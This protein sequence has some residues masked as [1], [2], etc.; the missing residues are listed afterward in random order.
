[1]KHSFLL[2]LSLILF[3][4]SVNAQ[5]RPMT[6]KDYDQ[7]KAINETQITHDGMWTI[8]TLNPQDGD[9]KLVFYPMRGN[10]IDTVNRANNVKISPNSELAVFKI[11][12]PEDSLTAAKKAKKKKESFPK[13]SLGIYQLRS[14][15]LEKIPAVKSFIFPELNN[16]WLAYHHYAGFPEKKDTAKVVK[17]AP[18]KKKESDETGSKLVLRHLTSKADQVFNFVYQYKFDKNAKRLAFATTGN[19]STIASGLYIYHTDKKSLSP[20]LKTKAKVLTVSFSEDGNQ[21]AFLTDP[22]TTKKALK[23][24]YQLYYWKADQETAELVADSLKNPAPAKWTV[25]QYYE[26]LFSKDGSKLFFGTVPPTLVKDTTI[27]EEDV[28]KV[29]VWNWKD[30]K[31]MTQQLATLSADLKKSYLAVFNTSNKKMNQLATLEIPVVKLTKDANEEVLLGISDLRYSGQHWDWNGTADL[32]AISVKDGRPSKVIEGIKPEARD[33][34]V[35]PAGKYIYWYSKADTAWFAYNVRSEKVIRLTNSSAFSDKEDDDHPDY[36][37]AYGAAGWTEEDN[38]LLIYDKFDIWS[39]DPSKGGEPKRWTKGR[40]DKLI[41]RYVRLDKDEKFIDSKKTLL[42]H[43]FNE[44]S[45]QSGYAQMTNLAERKVSILVLEDYW[46]SNS[47]FKAKEASDVVF[48]RERFESFPDL[49][50]SADMGFKEIRKISEANP[51]QKN[52]SWGSVEM[53]SWKSLEGIELKGLLYKPENFDPSKKYPMI[54]YFYEK[55]SDE[56]YRYQVPQPIRASVNYSYYVSNGYVLFVPDIVYKDGYPGQSAYNCIM[57]GVMKVLDM[58]FVD[59]TKLGIQGHS[60]GGY[61]TAYLI[62]RTDLFTAAEAGAPV[63]NMTSAYGG[64]RWDTGLSRMAQYENTQSRIGATLWEKQANY[65][66]NSPLFYLPQ[67]KTPLLMMHNDD[68]G[69]VPWYQGIE[70]FMGLK[71]LNKPVWMVNY[72]G[73][74]HGLTQRKNRKDWS[75]RMSQFFDHYL[76]GQ[77]APVWMSKGVPAVEKTLNYGFKVG[78]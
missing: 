27:L 52:I 60:W 71:R 62:T 13:D 54:T 43:I 33:L 24:N 48:T 59:K 73:E 25:S 15:S 1:M 66:E 61:Q 64:I 19:D 75:V 49:Y 44:R 41:H 72:N 29:D 46:Y 37:G 12:V 36:P 42:L 10:L 74:K 39:V 32:Y 56:L 23:K 18:K 68:D 65:I 78:D 50:T 20:V 57:P 38:E 55:L 7:W 3:G 51:Q 17:G 8:F 76:K 63:A 53:V 16:E 22:D 35:S 14:Q 11:N 28:V 6:H 31:L 26:P 67:V 9:G 45:K 34:S 69:A 5:K 70:M 2:L 77:P 30:P 21:M 47:V 4:Q 40:E 58:G